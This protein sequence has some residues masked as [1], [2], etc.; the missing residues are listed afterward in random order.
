MDKSNIMNKKNLILVIIVFSL[1]GLFGGC[2]GNEKKTFAVAGFQEVI[3]RAMRGD[4]HAND[5][6]SQL[7]DLT[8]PI[9]PRYNAFVIDSFSSKAGK[10]VYT[11]LLEY[12]NPFYNRF[13]IYDSSL[14]LLLIDKSLNGNLALHKIE[15][16]KIPLI[17]ITES[18]RSKDNIQLQ[19]I[20]FYAV[21]KDSAVL[22]LRTFLKYDDSTNTL[23]QTPKE[24]AGNLIMTEISAKPEKLFAERSFQFKLDTVTCTFKGDFGKFDAAVMNL[25]QGYKKKY[26]DDQIYDKKSA[27]VS[28]GNLTPPDSGK[29]YNNVKEKKAGFSITLPPSGWSTERNVFISSQ[30][31]KAM[32]GTIYTNQAQGAKISVLEIPYS[33]VAESFVNYTLDKTTSKNYIVRYTEKIPFKR[34]YLRFFEFTCVN[35]KFLVIFESPASSYERYGKD[36]ENIIGTFVIDC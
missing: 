22:S 15:Q 35:K 16:T 8:I 10:R 6:L 3:L 20:S 11:V 4:T 31:K 27:L 25:V 9:N 29:N 24:I 26:S 19:R 36:Y 2:G 28:I 5:T 1:I 17:S 18:F 13:A 33:D 12:P 23:T 7:F 14:N 34:N 32:Q 21:K 30:L